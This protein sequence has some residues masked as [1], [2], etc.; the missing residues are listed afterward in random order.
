MKRL[1]LALAMVFGVVGP[2][3]QAQSY[4][5]KPIRI[6]VPFPPG[7]ADVTARQVAP[8]L[9]EDLGQAIVIEN[10]AGANGLIG[11]DYVAKQAPDGYTLL[12]TANN[13]IVTGPV[14][15]PKEARYDPN[16]DLTHISLILTGVV[17]FAVSNTLPV[18]SLREFIDYAKKNPGKISYASVGVGSSQHIDGEI[19]KK[20]AGIDMVHVPFK[21]FGQIMPDLVAG[22]VQLAS[23]AYTTALPQ[24]AAGKLTIV[25]VTLKPYAK[26]P[27]VPVVE[28]VIGGGYERMPAWSASLHGPANMPRP[29]LNRIYAS[30][31]KA[32]AVNTELRSGFENDGFIVNLTPPDQFTAE[33]KE[34]LQRTA[35]LLK[36]SGVKLEQ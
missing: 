21:G 14:T 11:T 35:R 23:L 10:R 26:L 15:T 8:K 29:V 3:V 13:P 7:G 33:V 25:G 28:D 12:W 31:A 22:R 1:H 36:E 32:L 2:A 18:S 34:A 9:Q 5:G 30:L 6:V 4:P 24:V 20:R 19:I 16:A 27:G 17:T